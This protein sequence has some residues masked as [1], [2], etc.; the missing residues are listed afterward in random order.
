MQGLCFQSAERIACCLGLAL[1]G[2]P[3]RSKRKQASESKQGQGNQQPAQ[4]TSA[5][6]SMCV[7]MAPSTLCPCP[8]ALLPWPLQCFVAGQHYYYKFTDFT[9]CVVPL[10]VQSEV[11]LQL[12][13]AL[14][15]Q[16]VHHLTHEGVRHS[17]GSSN[18][19]DMQQWQ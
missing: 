17:S 7:C 13:P 4:L 12:L 3:L 6:A 14:E 11:H 2:C 8:T 5:A 9:H 1:T 16:H 18:G 15:D 10:L 19:S